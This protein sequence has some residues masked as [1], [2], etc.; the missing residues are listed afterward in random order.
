[1][2]YTRSSNFGVGA[3]WNGVMKDFETLTIDYQEDD[4]VYMFSDG[5][6]D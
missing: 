3:G 2:N 4:I 5:F 6:T 1:L